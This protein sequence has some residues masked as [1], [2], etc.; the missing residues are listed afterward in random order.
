MELH[1]P[2]HRIRHCSKNLTCS[3]RRNATGSRTIH[4]LWPA[5]THH[6]G[7]CWLDWEKEI[8]ESDRQDQKARITEKLAKE[9]RLL[10]ASSSS[11]SR[12]SGSHCATMRMKK[13]IQIIG[14]IPIF[15]ALG[16][17]RRLGKQEAVPARYEGLPDQ[18]SR[19][20]ARLFQCDRTAV[21]QSAL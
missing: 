14:D 18:R 8:S 12:S 19:S 17:R 7:R 16:Q 10:S 3:V 4:F 6:E 13:D 1:F 11:S 5:R 21:G 15:V 20:P 9:I 2:I